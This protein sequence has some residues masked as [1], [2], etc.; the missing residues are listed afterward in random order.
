MHVFRLAEG[1]KAQIV[2]V[3]R[4]ISPADEAVLDEYFPRWR[5]VPCQTCPTTIKLLHL[6]RRRGW[7]LIAIEVSKKAVPYCAFRLRRHETPA[8][9]VGS[10]DDG[11]PE[12]LLQKI[13]DHLYVPMGGTATC[14]SA[15]MALAIVASHFAYVT[16]D[17]TY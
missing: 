17:K 1:E 4:T 2:L 7:K 3:D 8:F 12:E 16:T 13:P 14:F 5:Y 15:G 10:E 9:V 11:I 6:I